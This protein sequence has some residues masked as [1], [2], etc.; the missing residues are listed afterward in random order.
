M[1]DESEN[2]FTNLISFHFLYHLNCLYTRYLDIIIV[3]I[4]IYAII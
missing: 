2:L 4:Y 1:F 3:Y